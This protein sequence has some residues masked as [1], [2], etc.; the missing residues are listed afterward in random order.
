M[1]YG[2]PIH[3]I[4]DVAL[5]IRSFYKRIRDFVQYKHATRDMNARYPDATAEEIAREDVCIICRENMTVWQDSTT[6]QGAETSR[7]GHQPIDE[8]QRAKKLPCGHLLHFACLRSWLERQQICP[9]CRT[10]V[11]TNN[12]R[13]SIPN[14]DAGPA[15]Q[16]IPGAMNQPAGG[17]HVYTFGPFRL[18]LGARQI[19]NPPLPNP[20]VGAAMGNPS[21]LML[22]RNS[23]TLPSGGTGIQAQLDQIEQYITRE[24][25]SLNLLSDQVQVVRALQS[26]LARLRIA[27]NFS[28]NVAPAS[29]NQMPTQQTVQTYRQVPLDAGHQDFPAGLMIPENWMLHALQ[30]VPAM[31]NS[32]GANTGPR[33]W[34]SFEAPSHQTRP[35]STRTQSVSQ[36][37][38][39]DSSGDPAHTSGIAGDAASTEVQAHGSSTPEQN[40]TLGQAESSRESGCENSPGLPKWSS[41]P[42]QNIGDTSGGQTVEDSTR[43]ET[44]QPKGKGKAV[45]VEDDTDDVGG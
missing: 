25:S 35:T 16:G 9:T 32:E 40:Q 24:I 42:I 39:L 28:G 2:M 1:F 3:I 7:G 15:I 4:R 41:A 37:P 26:E 34:R 27:R 36:A 18:V 11:L 19:N 21:G 13:P 30:R 43:S 6:H 23:N 17:P 5:T 14:Q 8:R 29:N 45:M 31:A 20:G 10:P 44:P 12:P 33:P 38:G 22:N